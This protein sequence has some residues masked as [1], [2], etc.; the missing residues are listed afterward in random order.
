MLSDLVSTESSLFYFIF[1]CKVSV[2]S[3]LDAKY[4][5]TYANIK[6]AVKKTGVKASNI[7]ACAKGKRRRRADI[8]G[9]MNLIN[10]FL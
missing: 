6:Q 1:E 5:T 10:M 2:Q 4:K 3:T 7:V 8:F 9:D